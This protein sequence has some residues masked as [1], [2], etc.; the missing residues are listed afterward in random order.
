MGGLGGVLGTFW[1]DFQRILCHLEQYV[2]IA[3][4]LGKPMVFIDFRGSGRARGLFLVMIGVFG[5]RV[6]D[7]I[8]DF[9]R[10][11]E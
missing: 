6:V 7:V 4:N 2:K 8:A 1:E 10:L 3:K 9:E 11:V 5:I